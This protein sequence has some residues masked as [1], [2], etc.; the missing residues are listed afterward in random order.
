MPTNA[1]GVRCPSGSAFW[2]D[3]DSAYYTYSNQY[4]ESVWWALSS[5]WKAG[6]LVKDYKIQPYCSRCG[7]TL[8]SHEVAQNYKDTDDPSVWVLFPV[9]PGQTITALDGKEWTVPKGLS[10]VAWTTTP[11]TLLG[12]SGIAVS[13]KMAYKVVR[14]PERPEELLLFAEGLEKPVPL[15]VEVDG[16]RTRLDL[17]ELPAEARFEGS[18]LQGLRYDRPFL[19]AP[20]DREPAD[21]PFDP[22]PSDEA[23]W[24]VFAA[25]Y[26]TMPRAPVWSTPHRPLARTTTRAVSALASPSFSP[27]TPKAR[28]TAGRG[29]SPLPV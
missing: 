7:T 10:L 21:G 17:R 11:W 23:G 19:T 1:S 5:L 29:P 2:I 13:P 3:L 24:R 25:D 4:I 27:S 9:H 15:D 6:L 28:S 18:D 16:K 8:S 22:P 12:H 14:H 20:A 26:V